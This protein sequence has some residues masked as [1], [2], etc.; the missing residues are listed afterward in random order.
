MTGA[1]AERGGLTWGQAEQQARSSKHV[2]TRLARD[3]RR[4]R[5]APLITLLH[6]I[7]RHIAAYHRTSSHIS[8]Q[9][10]T[11]PHGAPRTRGQRAWAEA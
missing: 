2:T 11:S 3:S 4:Q 10:R 7:P 5:G 6:R 9:V 8:A 1:K